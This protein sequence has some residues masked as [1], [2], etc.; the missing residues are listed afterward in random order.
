MFSG[1]AYASV[2]VFRSRY[3][4]P[5]LRASFF[6]ADIPP[7]GMGTARTFHLDGRS[8]GHSYRGIRLPRS[9]VLIFLSTPLLPSATVPNAA[10][11]CNNTVE[12]KGLRR[13]NG[14]FFHHAIKCARTLK[15]FSSFI[16]TSFSTS[17]SHLRLSFP[18]R[19]ILSR[20]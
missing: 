4:F 7:Y 6:T 2:R 15:S 16:S 14:P 9:N 20:N 17:G 1:V 8:S 3:V 11:V 18:N 5:A 10:A 19:Y 13:V 12:L